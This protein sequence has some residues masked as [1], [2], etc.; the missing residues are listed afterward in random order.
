MVHRWTSWAGHL[1]CEFAFASSQSLFPHI[2]IHFVEI[3]VVI[4]SHALSTRAETVW[5][6]WLESKMGQIQ[7]P[8]PGLVWKPR[9]TFTGHMCGVSTRGSRDTISL[10]RV[11]WTLPRFIIAPQPGLLKRKK[12]KEKPSESRNLHQESEFNSMLWRRKVVKDA[13]PSRP[14]VSV[15]VCHRELH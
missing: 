9:R 13:K 10:S 6:D 7:L 15:M 5:K 8:P 3:L 12:T 11:P 1:L 14:G 2:C 4:Q